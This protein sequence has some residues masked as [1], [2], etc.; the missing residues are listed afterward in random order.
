VI[1][2]RSVI[3]GSF[4]SDV[5]TCEMRSTQLA[6]T[7][8]VFEDT[9]FVSSSYVPFVEKTLYIG[10]TKSTYPYVSVIGVGIGAVQSYVYFATIMSSV[11]LLHIHSAPNFVGSFVAGTCISTTSANYIFA[12]MVRTDSGVMTGMY[13]APERDSI[14]NRAELVNAM[15]LEFL[16]PDSFIAGGIQLSDGAGLHAYIV[17]VNALYRKVMFG[18]RFIVDGTIAGG[19]RI[20][21]STFTHNIHMLSN[22]LTVSSIVKAMVLVEASLYM[23][24]SVREN[25]LISSVGSLSI[26]TTDLTGSITQQVHIYSHNAS[27]ECFD[28]AATGF[29]LIMT[30]GVEYTQNVTQAIVLS[31]NQQLTFSKLPVGFVRSNRD[32]FTAVPIVFKGTELPLT[33]TRDEKS[34][35]EYTFNTADEIP[36]SHPVVAPPQPPSSQPSSGPSGQPSSSPTAAPSVSPQ[37][38]SQPSTSGPTNTYR[39]TVKPSQRPTVS[40]SAEPTVRPS[41]KPSTSPTPRPTRSPTTT[42]STKPSVS[43]PVLFQPQ[44]RLLNPP[45]TPL[46][47]V[48]LAHLL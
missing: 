25:D 45:A 6:C 1:S 21:E 23:V 44:H 7:A 14:L 19:R 40:P 26:L 47:A 18:K 9:N 13:I 43:R 37:P 22:P 48:L 3:S 35:T 36:T 8:T 24:V 46:F 2:A 10:T 27:I 5:A 34:T 31:V 41:A 42:P 28:I 16:G 11:S 30:C 38:T 39:P 17:R 33:V 15:A 32:W 12:G 4:V 29:S 20:L